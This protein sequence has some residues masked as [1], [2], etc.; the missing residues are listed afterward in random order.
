[1]SAFPVECAVG[2]AAQAHADRV[3]ALTWRP[4][5]RGDLDAVPLGAAPCWRADAAGLRLWMR[6]GQAG[7]GPRCRVGAGLAGP[8]GGG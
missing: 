8:F 5:V 6:V 4:E 1:V 2:R 3:T 7:S